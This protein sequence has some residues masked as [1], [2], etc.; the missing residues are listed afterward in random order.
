MNYQEFI[1]KKKITIQSS[2]F[3][4]TQINPILF[5][6][7]RD[8]VRWACKKGK[9][10]IF[11]GTGLGKTFMQVEWARL[12]HEHIKN[13]VLIVAPLAVS[14]QT[15]GEAKKIGVTVN[16]CKEA[17]DVGPGINITNY[18]RLEKFIDMDWGAVVLDESSILKSSTGQTRT[19]IIEMFANTPYK[20]ACTATPAPNDYT[21]LGNHAEFIGVMNLTEMLAMFFTHDGGDTA[22]WRIKGHAVTRFWQWVAGWAVMMTK[23]AD[24]GYDN[25]QYDLPPLNIQ[26]I[27]VCTEPK[28][29]EVFVL[30]AQTLQERQQARRD[31]IEERVQAA[32]DIVAQNPD[33]IWMIWCNLNSESELLKKALDAVEVKGADSNDHK[34]RSM[35]DFAAGKIG[36]LVSKP[37]I[38]GFGMNFQVCHNVI[39][40]GLSDSFEE[41]YQAVR[42][43]WRFGQ[44]EQVNVYVVTADREG[45]VVANIERKERDFNAMLTGMISAT[46]EITKE[47]I[48]GTGRDETEYAAHQKMIL[49]EWMAV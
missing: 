44:T 49:P 24:L 45:A 15:I 31:S 23:P 35:I 5:D 3:E 1:E 33:E 13:P 32:A 46:Q 14:V 9:S 21:E 19:A 27:T 12:V 43:C 2:G 42:R 37:S 38:C 4:P 7:Q 16:L 11:A 10:C 30:E 29:H 36:R 47:N 17:A 22:K 39:F 34:E 25:S 20:L 8:I 40:V 18:E 48:Q 41:Y 28:E 26:Q 6:F